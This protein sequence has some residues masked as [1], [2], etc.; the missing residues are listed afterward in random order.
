MTVVAAELR[1]GALQGGISRRLRLLDAAAGRSRQHVYRVGRGW[2][3]PMSMNNRTRSGAPCAT[4]CA[5]RS[6]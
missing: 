4:G 2:D 3:W 1:V 6:S 5:A